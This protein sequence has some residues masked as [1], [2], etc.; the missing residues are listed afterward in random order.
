MSLPDGFKAYQQWLGIRNHFTQDRY[1]YIKYHGKVTANRETFQT[2][3]FKKF[4]YVLATRYKKELRDFFLSIYCKDGNN[5]KFIGE[6]MDDKYHKQYIDWK[7]RNEAMRKSFEDD[8][9]TIKE[10][11][12]DKKIS[13][14]D[15][16]QSPNKTLPPIMQLERQ[17]YISVETAIIINYYTN[18]TRKECSDPR[19][20]D[21][22][23]RLM[24]YKRFINIRKHDYLNIMREK[25]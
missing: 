4:F 15:V 20:K 6:L 7:R 9:D 19:W 2:R 18:F 23:K 14:K 10:F 3:K 13:F 25:L 24:K 16:L 1:D 5:D 12:Q 8:L 11:M 17:N 22:I 21:D